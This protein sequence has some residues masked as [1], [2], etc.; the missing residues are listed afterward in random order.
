MHYL[1]LNGLTYYHNKLTSYLLPSVT[2]SDN[3]KILMV[4]NGEWT[5]VDPIN[6]YSGT[7]TPNYSVGVDGDI[8][9]QITE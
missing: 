3:N 6:V 1:D 7:D 5:L 9:L 4:E 2:S 8:Y